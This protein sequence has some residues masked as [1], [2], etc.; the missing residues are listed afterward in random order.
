M[1]T[2]PRLPSRSDAPMTA[3]DRAAKER[4]QLAKRAHGR[5]FAS[6]INRDH[7]S[8][9][10]AST[11]PNCCADPGS[12]VMPCA[13]SDS[14]NEGSLT[15]RTRASLS[16]ATTGAGTPCGCQQPPR[17]RDVECRK[18]GFGERRNVGKM[19]GARLSGL[20]ERADLARLDQRNRGDVVDR[21]L[22]VAG[23]QTGERRRAALIGN[24]H[25]VHVGG[26]QEQFHREM[27][28]GPDAGGSVVE[29]VP[30][31][32]HQ[33]EQAVEVGDGKLRIDDQHIGQLSHRADGR[34]ARDRIVLD[35][36]IELLARGLC[37]RADE[38]D[39]CSRRRAVAKRSRCR[40][41]RRRPHGFRPRSAGPGC[42]PSSW[43]AGGPEHP[44]HRR[45]G[46]A[47]RA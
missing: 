16:L 45:A 34:E 41:C 19:R 39:A 13:S 6:S 37:Q 35:R 7:L 40:S 38:H 43:P 1:A 21:E 33:L 23:R 18:A 44:S 17:R 30:R 10:L 36:R 11:A 3:T 22:R 32:A 25:R 26:A 2:P 24:V 14:R 47:R 8:A 4:R 28:R 9:S 15:A 46:T 31:A 27:R 29:L 20:R 5:I 42:R 12:G